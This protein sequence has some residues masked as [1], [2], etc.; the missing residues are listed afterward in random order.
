MH[1]FCGEKGS[2]ELLPLPRV[3][4]EYCGLQRA[5]ISVKIQNS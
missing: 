5:L 2:K 4:C 1:Q 3:Y